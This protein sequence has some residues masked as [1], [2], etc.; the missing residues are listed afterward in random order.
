MFSVSR[1]VFLIVVA[2]GVLATS[3][4]AQKHSSKEFG[5]FLTK[6]DAAQLEM[7]NGKSDAFKA[8]WSDSEEIT[9][10]GGFGGTV[11][12]GP[13]AIDARLDWVGQQFS[14]GTNKIER[15]VATASGDFAYV[16]QLEHIRFHVPG[17]L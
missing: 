8:L 10:S 12:K 7:Q 9:L 15:L 4:L 5:N 1:K 11:E 13:K 16:V 2:L 14:N 3:T 17:K 6:L